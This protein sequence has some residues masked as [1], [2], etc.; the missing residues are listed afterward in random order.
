MVTIHNYTT[1]K[2]GDLW[3]GLWHCF[4][5]ISSHK[6]S[7]DNNLKYINPVP[8]NIHQ[9]A[10]LHWWQGPSKPS[11]GSLAQLAPML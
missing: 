4:T 9:Q 1:Y 5:H 3:D 8:E 11:E 6:R 2:N 10:A 7:N